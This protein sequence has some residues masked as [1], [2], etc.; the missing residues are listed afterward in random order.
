MKVLK[1]L[2]FKLLIFTSVSAQTNVFPSTGNVGIGIL[3]PVEKLHI[4]DEGLFR[5]TFEASSSQDYIRPILDFKRSRGFISAKTAVINN[6]KLGSIYFRGYDGTNYVESSAIGGIAE[7]D[8]QTNIQRGTLYFSTNDG[9]DLIY[10]VPKIKMVITSSGNVLINPSTNVQGNLL[11]NYATGEGKLQVNGL[12]KAKS[13]KVEIVN[14]PDY[15]FENNYKLNSLSALENFIKENKHLPEM[16]TANDVATNG[17]DLGEI[18]KLLLKKIEELTLH[19]I[20]KDKELKETNH[21]LKIMEVRQIE[22]ETL[23]KKL[24]IGNQ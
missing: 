17:I 20:D 21:L 12:I 18:N 1:L 22:I 4:V 13:V 19:L 6:D 3:S 14:W 11:P 7:G 8:A 15:V 10:N 16:P 23:L 2:S 24:K 9:N 5:P